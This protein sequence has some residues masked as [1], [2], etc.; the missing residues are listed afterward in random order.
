[1]GWHETK[2]GTRLEATQALSMAVRQQFGH[3]SA[4]AARGLA[5]RHR[6]GSNVIAK[7]FRHQIRFRGITPTDTFVAAPEANGVIGRLLRMMQE[8][9]IHGRV[10]HSIDEARE[11]V[12][13]CIARCK[14]AWLIEKNGSL[15]PLDA[16]AKRMD[17]KRPRAA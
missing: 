2:G 8:Q 7:H 3:L 17:A 10:F 11:A 12:R 16:R 14:A 1:L 15:S 5:L 13:D 9:V 6:H 4:G